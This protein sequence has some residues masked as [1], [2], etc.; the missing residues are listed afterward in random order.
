MFQVDGGRTHQDQL[1]SLQSLVVT[2]VIYSRFERTG[3]DL[4][5]RVDRLV[6]ATL[7]VRTDRLR[8]RFPVWAVH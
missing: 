2:G 1:Q 8:D 6:E 7:W 5:D 3:S 4:A